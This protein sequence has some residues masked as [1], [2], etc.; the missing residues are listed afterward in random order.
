MK[1]WKQIKWKEYEQKISNVPPERLWYVVVS[2]G[3]I[4]LLWPIHN[5]IKPYLM[6]TLYVFASVINYCN[7][8][9]LNSLKNLM[10]SPSW[11][12]VY[13]VSQWF[14]QKI[15]AF[16]ENYN[17]I[18]TL[19]KLRK[20]FKMFSHLWWITYCNS[21]FL[22]SLKNLMKSPSWFNVYL[23]RFKSSRWLCQNFL[24]FLENYNHIKTFRKLRMHFMEIIL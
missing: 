17:H 16:L 5:G 23:V 20:H 13:L 8:G 4:I 3:G 24:A 18:K 10:K 6:E 19:R 11:F 2:H 7:S 21:G 22:N 12:K 9:F 14:C 15:L 1:N